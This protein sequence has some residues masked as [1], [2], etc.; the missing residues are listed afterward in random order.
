[1]AKYED[2]TL[3]EIYQE[4]I[5]YLLSADSMIEEMLSKVE[6]REKRVNK[7]G[8]VCCGALVRVENTPE[9]RTDE[10]F[11]ICDE[12]CRKFFGNATLL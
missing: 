5:R 7:A 4:R 8:W 10:Q 9:P 11:P 2:K 1:M 3:G 6:S 12:N